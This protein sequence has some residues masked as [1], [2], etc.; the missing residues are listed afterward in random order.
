MKKKVERGVTWCFLL[1]C[2]AKTGLELLWAA[3][4]SFFLSSISFSTFP[5]LWISDF[6][7]SLLCFLWIC[8]TLFFMTP[9]SLLRFL[10]LYSRFPWNPPSLWIHRLRI[11]WNPTFNFGFQ[12]PAPRTCSACGRRKPESGLKTVGSGISNSGF[13]FPRVRSGFWGIG[14]VE[15]LA[16]G[17]RKLEIGFWASWKTAG[18]TRVRNRIWVSNLGL[19]AIGG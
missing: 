5:L 19:F 3:S 7:L 8:L 9:C 18:K 16:L 14:D 12:I 2:L 6:P 13:W 1:Y 11:R 15:W 17:F 4:G 10:F